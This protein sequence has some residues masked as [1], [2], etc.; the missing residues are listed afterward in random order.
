MSIN[1]RHV[2]Y[3]KISEAKS[4]LLVRYFAANLEATQISSFT[5]LNRNTA[6]RYLTAIRERIAEYCDSH[7]IN[8]TR[9]HS[10]AQTST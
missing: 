3:S 8:Q 2:Y 1:N 6:N 4:R 5:E 10:T 9:K 7:S